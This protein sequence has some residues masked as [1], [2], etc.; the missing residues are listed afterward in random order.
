MYGMHPQSRKRG[1]HAYGIRP[2]NVPKGAMRTAPDPMTPKRI[3][4]N[5]GPSGCLLNHIRQATK[6]LN[7]AAIKNIPAQNIKRI[8]LTGL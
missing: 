2:A 7:N 5:E 6:A 8:H 3:G 4:A 1:S